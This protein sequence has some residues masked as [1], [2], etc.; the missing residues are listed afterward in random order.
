[1][2]VVAAYLS[3]IAD[4]KC[5]SDLAVG[6]PPAVEMGVQLRGRALGTQAALGVVGQPPQREQREVVLGDD[7]GAVPGPPE[8]GE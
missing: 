6:H 5:A 2:P 4:A 1:M 8:L 3:R 7:I